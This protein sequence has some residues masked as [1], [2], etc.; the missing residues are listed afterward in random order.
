MLSIDG[1]AITR[2]GTFQDHI[3]EAHPGTT[4]EI[5]FERD[6]VRSTVHP[7]LIAWP[8]ASY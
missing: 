3:F 2:S 6:G 1:T 4:T 5:V 7:T 8:I